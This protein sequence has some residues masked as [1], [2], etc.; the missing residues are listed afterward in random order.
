MQRRKVFLASTAAEAAM[1]EYLIRL[2]S[3]GAMPELPGEPVAVEAALGRVTAEA[4]FAALSSPHYHAAAM[5]GIAVRAAE[6]FGAAETTPVRLSVGAQAVAVDT[7]DPVPA[8][9]DAV[10]MVED[11]N[12]PTDGV[13]EI[14]AP[15]VP[16]QHIR[17]L[18]EDIVATELLLPANHRIRAVDLGALLAGGLTKVKVRRRPVVAILPTG[19]E[20]VE[21]GELLQTGSIIESN[22]RVLAGLVTEWGGQPWRC[23]IVPDDYAQ[24][25]ARVQEAAAAADIVV[26]NAGS[27]A[28]SEDF[29]AA[30]IA[31]LGELTVHGVAIKPGKPVMLGLVGNKPCIGIPGYPVSA[32]ITFDLFVKSLVSRLQGVAVPERETVSANLTRSVVSALGAEEFVRVALGVVGDKMVATPMSRGAGIT[33]SLV[34][35][36]GWLRVPRLSEGY[37]EGQTV[38]VELLRPRAEIARRLVAIGSHDVALDLLASCLRQRFPA[39]SLSSAHVGSLGGL[40][41]LRRGEAHLAGIHLL[42]EATGEYNF[43]YLE[44]YLPD[45]PIVLVNLV[46]REQGLMVAPGNPKR[47]EGIADLAR[48]EVTFV[49]RQRGAG[50]RLLL[51]FRLKQLGIPGERIQGYQREE[52]THLAVAAAVQSGAADAGLGIR[53]VAQALG[54]DFLPVSPERYDLAIPAHLFPT[55]P[56]Q[57]LLAVIRSPQFLRA[58]TALGGYDLRDTGKVLEREKMREGGL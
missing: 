19:T 36:D 43:P 17:P 25:R 15:A 13:V 50:T 53:T 12:W 33:L 46:Y 16:W 44:Q 18:G 30:I 1:E 48:P 7:G 4:V 31:E 5:D 10:I 47:I 9:F 28:G 27:S 51:D 26:I 2:E 49:N 42:D 14:V 54:L 11:L 23:G 29:T 21:P 24:I 55:D 41:A 40:I 58:V 22:S 35:A 32:V 45:Q 20:L 38:T 37:R 34:R 57:N 3:R 8:G 39:M 6:T 56:I 52:F